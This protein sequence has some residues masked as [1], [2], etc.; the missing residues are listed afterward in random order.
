MTTMVHMSALEVVATIGAVLLVVPVPSVLYSPAVLTCITAPG[1]EDLVYV[2][3][4]IIRCVET[5]QG[6]R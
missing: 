1:Q 5:C 2:A 3:L 6:V 4:R